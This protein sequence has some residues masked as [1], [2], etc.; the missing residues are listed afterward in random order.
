MSLSVGVK[1]RHKWEKQLF[2]KNDTW[3]FLIMQVTYYFQAAADN[4][5][6]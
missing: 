2:M 1:N 6:I 3:M 4:D 5:S